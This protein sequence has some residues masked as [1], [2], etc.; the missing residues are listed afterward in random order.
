MDVALPSFTA[1]YTQGFAGPM[2]ASKFGPCRCD[3][4]AGLQDMVPVIWSF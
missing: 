4:R 2:D 1:D 3:E